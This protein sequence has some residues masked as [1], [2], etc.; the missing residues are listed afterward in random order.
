MNKEIS[1]WVAHV[2]PIPENTVIS[3]NRGKLSLGK[4][5]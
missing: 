4:L 1:D 5:F 2:I 3:I